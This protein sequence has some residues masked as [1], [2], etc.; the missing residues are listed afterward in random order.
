M[1]GA[2]AH[3]D[4]VAVWLAAVAA[5]LAGLGYLARKSW[6]AVAWLRRLGLKIERLDDLA[7]YELQHN[8][9]SSIKDRVLA[10]QTTLDEHLIQSRARDERQQTR[11]TQT[12]ELLSEHTAAIAHL[13]EAL[14]IVA[15]S[16][17][18]PTDTQEG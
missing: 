7:S 15:R 14:P 11:D 8:G 1:T 9:G 16:T 12:L 5:G 6:Q 2:L 18:D 3:V 10:T 4:S 17:P 13:A